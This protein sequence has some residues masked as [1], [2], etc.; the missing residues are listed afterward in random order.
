M[1]KRRQQSG[2]ANEIPALRDVIDTRVPL[3]VFYLG[4]EKKNIPNNI[5]CNCHWYLC[6]IN[7][8]KKKFHI[9][10]EFS[11]IKLFFK[12]TAPFQKYAVD[13]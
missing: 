12:T 8:Q 9:R 5:Q 10:L 4:V 13:V 3:S 7:L 2:Q 11:I 1:R 6:W